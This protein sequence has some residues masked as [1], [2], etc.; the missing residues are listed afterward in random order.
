MASPRILQLSANAKRLVLVVSGIFTPLSALSPTQK[1]ARPPPTPIR[2]LASS[3]RERL[4]NLAIADARTFIDS[5]IRIKLKEAF[6]KPLDPFFERVFVILSRLFVNILNMAAMALIPL[7]ADPTS[8]CES[9]FSEA[10]R[11]PIAPAIPTSEVT[12]MLVVNA[13][14]LS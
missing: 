2:P 3:A 8:S 6:I 9:V 4:P 13:C 7:S 10:V 11:T 1:I 12:L 14:K 5:A